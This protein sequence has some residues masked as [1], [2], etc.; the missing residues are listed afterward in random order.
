[1]FAEYNYFDFGT[2]TSN[3]YA[4]GLVPS[5]GAAGAL[6]DTVSLR[7]RSQQALVGVNYRFDWA[8]PVVAKY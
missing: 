4:T 7:L 5:F 6:S 1:M 3:I 2:K 8:D